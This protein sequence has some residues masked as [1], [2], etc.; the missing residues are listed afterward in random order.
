[1]ESFYQITIKM[2]NPYMQVCVIANIFD[3]LENL[4]KLITSQVKV[5]KFNQVYKGI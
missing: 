5:A 1:M 2:D 4:R 3:Q